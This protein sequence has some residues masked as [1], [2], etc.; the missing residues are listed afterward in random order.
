MLCVTSVDVLCVECSCYFHTC[1]LAKCSIVVEYLRPWLDMFLV[2][3]IL[4]V[5]LSCRSNNCTLGLS[6]GKTLSEEA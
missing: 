4:V 2:L 3:E 5:E 1:N 6:Y